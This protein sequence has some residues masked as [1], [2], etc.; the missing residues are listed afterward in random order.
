MGYD[1]VGFGSYTFCLQKFY[2]CMYTSGTE[3]ILWKNKVRKN[4]AQFDQFTCD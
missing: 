3:Y 2:I 1:F 4:D